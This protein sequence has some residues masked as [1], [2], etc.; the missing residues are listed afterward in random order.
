M[1]IPVRFRRLCA[2]A[3]ALCLL[4]GCGK[5][6]AGSTQPTGEAADPTTAT[7]VPAETLPAPDPSGGTFGLSYYADAGFNPYTCTRLAN[8][9]IMSL[10]YQSLFVV[11]T[12]FEPQAMLCAD[13]TV[14]DDLR[15]HTFTLGKATFANGTP[16]TAQDVAASL[17]AAMGSPVYGSRFYHVNNI[18]TPD[19][20][21][22]VLTTDTPYE[23]LPLLLDVPIVRAEDVEEAQPMGSGPY[24]LQGGSA[25]LSLER[26]YN[27]AGQS[28]LTYKKITLIPVT[29][30]AEVRNSF[31]F[32]QTS[33]SYTDPGSAS[34][35]DYRCDYEL[36]DCPSGVML[37]LTCNSD[38]GI[39]QDRSLRAALTYAI[40][41]EA[42]VRD[43][44]GEFS[45]AATL[46]ADPAS[47][48]Y[49]ATLAA[50]YQYDPDK[51]ASTVKSLS[52]QGSKITLLVNGADPYRVSAAEQIAANL[53]EG[54]LEV[55]IKAP[56]D[57]T[58]EETLLAWNFDLHL[59]ETRLSPNFDLTPFFRGWGELA[60]AR[61]SDTDLYDACMDALEN[62]GN[63]YNLHQAVMT[64]GKL[65]PI[66]FRS[67][68]VYVNRGS[69]DRLEPALDHVIYMSP[70]AEVPEAPLPATDPTQ[71]PEPTQDTTGET[72]DTTTP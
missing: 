35:A 4:T 43:L 24:V 1:K 64:D 5:K 51:F 19:S 68:A 13:Y 10:L 27:W 11:T 56:T 36:Y 50:G 30:T 67:Y 33:L 22:L 20:S 28:P 48:F 34:R 66:L 7:T 6:P 54:G 47:P 38:S 12:S 70:S 71:A 31:E 25:N 69:A 72:E 2:L 44:Y 18:Q 9:A 65:C 57:D 53:T 8:R 17:E 32:G 41:R 61:M 45:R 21:T 16:V 42:L 52:L 23:Q 58:Y 46:P 49:D 40:D 55:E 29:S 59:G 15:G 62:S 3:L 60:Y 37:Y 26:R 14:S 63:Y 39:F